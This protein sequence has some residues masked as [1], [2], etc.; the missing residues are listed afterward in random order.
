MRITPKYPAVLRMDLRGEAGN[1]FA[2][3]GAAQRALKRIGVSAEK[4]AAYA[5]EA[6]AGDYEELIATT[7]RWL[8]FEYIR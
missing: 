8:V 7:E 3:I 2:I 6:T 4:R 1:A 5:E